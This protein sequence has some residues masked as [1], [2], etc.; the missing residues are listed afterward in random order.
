MRTAAKL[1]QCTQASLLVLHVVHERPGELAYPRPRDRH[2]ALIP[3]DKIARSMVADLLKRV[4][5]APLETDA[6]EGVRI[7]LVN[8]LPASRI[9][10]VATQECASMIVMGSHG[11]SRLLHLLMGSV[12]EQVLR[13][14]AVPVTIVRTEHTRSAPPAV[15]YGDEGCAEDEA[16]HRSV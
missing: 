7:R 2:E 11:R 4:S 8:G 1:A 16:V 12:T 14:S 3:L 9:C 6:L 10:E 5:R 15:R 13:R